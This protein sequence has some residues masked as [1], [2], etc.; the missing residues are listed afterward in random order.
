[1]VLNESQIRE[2]IKD[3][4]LII[5]TEC[6]LPI[7]VSSSNVTKYMDG[8]FLDSDEGVKGLIVGRY[9]KDENPIPEYSTRRRVTPG[10]LECIWVKKIIIIYTI[11]LTREEIYDS[12]KNKNVKI[13]EEFISNPQKIPVT[14]TDKYTIGNLFGNFK[15][16]KGIIVGKEGRTPTYCMV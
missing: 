11:M 3:K 15:D 13:I 8:D 14:N 10:F 1:M 5:Y 7:R 4:K 16:Y 6:E 9:N 12:A 2:I